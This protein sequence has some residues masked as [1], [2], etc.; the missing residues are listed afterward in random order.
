MELKKHA[1]KI[2]IGLFGLMSLSALILS[3]KTFGELQQLKDAPGVD[4]TSIQADID[5]I[6]LYMG[7]LAID[8]AALKQQVEGLAFDLYDTNGT[9]SQVLGLA[10]EN[11]DVIFQD[12]A[13]LYGTF[14]YMGYDCSTAAVQSLN[15]CDPPWQGPGD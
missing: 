5:E 11:F 14:E 9:I 1:S 3:F 2:L 15:F 12:L 4:L 8:A 10:D 6:N 13:Y 7:S